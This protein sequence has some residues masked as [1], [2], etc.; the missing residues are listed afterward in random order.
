MLQIVRRKESGSLGGIGFF[1]QV[2]L[3]AHVRMF[4]IT[5]SEAQPSAIN[6]KNLS[7]YVACLVTYEEQGCFRYL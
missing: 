5:L 7:V 4:F 2:R 3:A 1:L 6:R